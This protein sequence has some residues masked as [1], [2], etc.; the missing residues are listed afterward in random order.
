MDRLALALLHDRPEVAAT[1]SG[2]AEMQADGLELFQRAE[3]EGR[4][5]TFS[6]RFRAEGATPW[7]ALAALG[8]V[9]WAEQGWRREVPNAE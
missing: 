6:G 5:W 2:L 3:S 7:E 1:L 8:R 4:G 9:R